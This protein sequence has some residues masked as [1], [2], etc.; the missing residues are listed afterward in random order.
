MR[1]VIE[2]IIAAE[3]AAKA[4]LETAHAEAESILKVAR[5]QASD[6]VAAAGKEARRPSGRRV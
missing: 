6:L 3:A 1:E 2:K 5:K 4:V